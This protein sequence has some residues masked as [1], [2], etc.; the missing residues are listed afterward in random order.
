MPAAS[1]KIPI[2]T[3]R[4]LQISCPKRDRRLQTGWEGFFPYYA[5]FPET[6]ATKLL[7]SARLRNGAVVADPW[8]GSGTTTF[9]AAQLGHA[10]WGVDVNPVMVIVAKA[11]L[12][13]PSEADALR[14]LAATIINHVR[15]PRSPA[16]S[17]P[18][19]S[20]FADETAAA[21]RAIEEEI[22][23]TVVGELTL[24]PKGVNLAS[25]AGTA[26]TLYVALF[27]ACRALTIPFRASNPTWLKKAKSDAE[28]I[29]A[30]RSRIVRLFTEN[31]R[32][33]AASLHARRQFQLTTE[34]QDTFIQVGDTVELGLRPRSVD[35]FLTSPPYCTRLDYAAA[36]RV[37]L[38]VLAGLV[39]DVHWQLQRSMIGSTIAPKREIEP[40]DAWG[41][42]CLSFLDQVRTHSSKASSGYY[43]KTHLDYFDKMA[44]S[45]ASMREGLKPN[46]VAVLVVQDSYYK[47]VYNDLPKIISE[48]AESCGLRL[49]RED[50]FSWNQSMARINPYTKAYKR[51]ASATEAVLCFSKSA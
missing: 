27:A 2:D 11:R 50:R 16:P 40:D 25:I 48:M 22:R 26:A 15:I 13:P 20:W 3:I 38:A 4:R 37:E 41:Q 46:G 30:P 19:N 28:R 29:S 24:G 23:R 32:A 39:G 12:L 45:L 35:F 8:N 31:V 9:A 34:Q 42:T 17:D 47:D 21:I 51:T 33:M 43:L 10:A 1:A 36:T 5:G 6:F 7:A 44:R 49:V 18:L 14:P